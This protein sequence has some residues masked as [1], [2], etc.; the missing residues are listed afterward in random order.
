MH[1][2]Q[3]R[4]CAL[5]ADASTDQLFITIALI[6]NHVLRDKLWLVNII[7]MASIMKHIL[8]TLNQESFKRK[9]FKLLSGRV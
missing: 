3:L 1:M 6:V 9:Y 5:S 8:C 7:I 4:W 2:L